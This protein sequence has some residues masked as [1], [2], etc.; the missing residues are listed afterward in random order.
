[1]ELNASSIV[2]IGAGPGGCATS[3]FL[4][5]H[6]IPHTI[7]DKAVF[8]RDKV[9][10]DALSG[11]TVYVLNQLDPTIVPAFDQQKEQFIESWGVK[12]VA[13]NGKAIDIPFKQ[14]MSKEKYPPGFISKRTDFDNELFNRLDKN[15]ATVLDGTEVTE[16][17]R[18]DDLFDVTIVKD[19]STQILKNIKLLIGAE[20]DRSIVSK[21]LS[22]NKKENDHYCAGIRA[23]YEGVEG[24]HP[25]NFIELHFLPEML[26]GYFWIFPLPNGM[27]NIGA[28][29]LSSEVSKRKVNLKA[30]ML[31]AIENNPAISARFK[32]A[33]LQGKI[34]GWGLP[35]GSKKRPVSGDGFLLV[36]DAGSLI[37]PFTGEGI[38][39]ALYSGMMAA[40]QIKEAVKQNRFDAAFLK[41][42]DDAFYARQWDELKLSH[43]MQKLVKFPWLFNFVVNKAHKNKALRET[44]SCMFEDLDLRAKLRN[45]LFYVKL[46]MNDKVKK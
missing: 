36:G 30:D 9:C 17:K 4:A 19:N 42:Y 35:L 10:G 37:D 44:I 31:K 7:I 8:P 21:K 16:I 6:K 28:G 15:Y 26:P 25:Q 39:N 43:T 38:G 13:P 45:P 29:M 27:A 2:I 18:N 1:M 5:K 12:F 3:L 22:P 20:G 11:K 41:Q 14:D 24:M 34:Q 40:I 46:L 33:K 23:Y 32:N